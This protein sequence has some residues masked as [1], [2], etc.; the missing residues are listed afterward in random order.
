MTEKGKK[1]LETEGGHPGGEMKAETLKE[2]TG[3]IKI[4]KSRKKRMERMNRF[5][6]RGKGE[7]EREEAQT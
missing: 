5:G 6:G 7:R 2:T 1:S 4:W 3:I